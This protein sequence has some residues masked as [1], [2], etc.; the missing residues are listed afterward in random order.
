MMSSVAS[1]W[2][3]AVNMGDDIVEI[4]EQLAFSFMTFP[5]LNPDTTI[6]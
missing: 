1:P 4:V 6:P 2:S 5:S 3:S